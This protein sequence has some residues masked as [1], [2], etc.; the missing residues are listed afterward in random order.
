MSPE[1]DH[2][3]IE[4]LLGAYALGALD[5]EERALVREHLEGCETCTA[6]LRRLEQARNALPLA[7]DPVEP[8]SRLREQILTATTSVAPAS[9]RTVAAPRPIRLPSRRPPSWPALRG[10]STAVAAAAV[11]AFALGAGLGLG[12]GRSITP[13]PPA[14]T[15]AQYSLTG[16]G[17]MAGAQGLVFEL[18]QQALTLVEFNNLPDLETGKVYELWLIPAHGQPVSAGVFKPDP[19][20]NH[21]VVLARSLEGVAV[22]AVTKEAG[23]N[24]TS[25]PTQ[26][27]ELAGKV[28]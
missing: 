20:G 17:S 11:I 18:K 24:G 26:Q 7:V 5:S 23:P 13:T 3:E 27:P 4:E 22:M 9:R 14:S 15:V 6:T 16:T 1:R 12:I 8:P 21:V 25:A 19:G 10:V 2:E 28:Q